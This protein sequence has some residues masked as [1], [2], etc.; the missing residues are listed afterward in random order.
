M[1]GFQHVTKSFG[2]LALLE[3]F[4]VS[5]NLKEVTCLLGPSGCG[6]STILKI[7]AGLEE[8]Y[9]GQVIGIEGKTLSFV[10]Q[11][12]RLLPWLTVRENLLYVLQDKLPSKYLEE[13]I[14]YFLKKV[15]L[16]TVKED[17]PNTL[18]GGM[19]QRVSL[20]RAFAMPHDILLLDEPF[21]GL[22]I[23]L[24]NQLMTLLEKLIA[25]ECKTVIMV[26]HDET[27]ARRLAHRIIYLKG[28]PLK[29]IKEEWLV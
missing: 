3:D 29:I 19:K 20:V 7:L 24:K 6:K 17:Y 14:E 5:F 25:E 12:S 13:R 22:N 4:S 2:T 28:Q 21:Q 11:E 26:T 16:L 10:F 18:S 1:I 9:E 23:E 27:E 8:A 15:D